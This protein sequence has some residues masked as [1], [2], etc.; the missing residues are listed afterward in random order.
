MEKDINTL[1]RVVDKL[2]RRITQLEK[3]R[4]QSTY[5]FR[6][7]EGRTSKVEYN[8]EKGTA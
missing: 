4:D 8:N 7:L 6:E 3:E 5:L 2:E 1:Y